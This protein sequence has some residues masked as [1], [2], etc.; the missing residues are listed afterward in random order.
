MDFDGDFFE[1]EIAPLSEYCN[2]C[3]YNTDGLKKEQEVTWNHNLDSH[4]LKSVNHQQTFEI[5]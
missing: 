2:C 3:F 1:K 4:W 5:H